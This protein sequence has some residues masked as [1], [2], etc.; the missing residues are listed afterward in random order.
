MLCL[1]RVCCGTGYVG[2]RYDRWRYLSP[3]KPGNPCSLTVPKQ[4]SPQLAETIYSTRGG[5]YRPIKFQGE[6]ESKVNEIA[7]CLKNPLLAFTAA[8][9]RQAS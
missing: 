5:R 3:E 2:L 8:K 9:Q 7:A 1:R 4:V 6:Y